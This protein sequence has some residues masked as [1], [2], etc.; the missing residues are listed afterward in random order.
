MKTELGE[1][2]CSEGDIVLVFEPNK[3]RIKYKLEIIQEFKS[4]QDGEKCVAIVKCISN[5]KRV[6]LDSPINR[7]YPIEPKSNLNVDDE[8]CFNKWELMLLYFIV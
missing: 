2:L 1:T 3:K 6:T 8:P 4:S 7:L 5:N